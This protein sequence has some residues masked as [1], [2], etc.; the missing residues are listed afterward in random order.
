MILAHLKK[1]LLYGWA[2]FPIPYLQFL[3]ICWHNC[4]LIFTKKVFA[5]LLI[6]KCIVS[7]FLNIL[8]VDEIFLFGDLFHN[9]GSSDNKLYKYVCATSVYSANINWMHAIYEVH[10]LLDIGYIQGSNS[11]FSGADK[12]LNYMIIYTLLPLIIN[13]T[14]FSNMNIFTH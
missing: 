5:L 3:L 4:V 14:F 2:E 12:H 7:Y 11:K 8:L 9:T 13:I 10:I 6:N 1:K